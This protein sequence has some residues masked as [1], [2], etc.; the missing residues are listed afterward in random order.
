[1]TRRAARYRLYGLCVESELELPCRPAAARARRE[2][3]LKAG[4]PAKFRRSRA[5]ALAPS[6]PKDWFYHGRLPGG[7]TYLQWSGLFEFLIS[8][9]GRRIE[10]HNLRRVGY[11]SLTTYLLGQVLSVSLL[12]LGAEPLHGTAVVVDGEAIVLLGAPGRGKSTLGAALL[13]LGYPVLTDDLVALAVKGPRYLVHAGVPRLK[14]FPHVARRLLDH[15]TGGTPLNPET[16]KQILP[17]GHGQAHRR[18]VPLRALYLLSPPRRSD[19]SVRIEPLRRGEAFLELVASSF[20]TL[21]V[22]PERLARQ[23]R[24]ATRLAERVSVKRLSYPRK[25]AA[26]PAVCDAILGDLEAVPAP[27]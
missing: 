21:A 14:L 4:D 11:E 20:N 15:R 2:V 17:L 25:F 19:R 6:A 9:D 10:Y 22:D 1:M 13:G 5:C 23:F 27:V 3:T 12:A 26:L 18:A 24:F 7:S 8:P 16:V